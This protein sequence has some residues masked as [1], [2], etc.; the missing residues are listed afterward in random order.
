MSRSAGR[1]SGRRWRDIAAKVYAEESCCWLC[2]GYVDQRLPYTHPMARGADHLIQI[3]HGGR[4]HDRTNARMSHQR[5]NTARSN[6]LRG[7]PREQCA[8]SMGLPCAVLVPSR[9][10]GYLTTDLSGV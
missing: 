8:C 10:R 1:K 3:Q 6:R 2:G 7:L 5:C 9:K 4:E